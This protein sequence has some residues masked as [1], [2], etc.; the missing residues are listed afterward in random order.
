MIMDK[1]GQMPQTRNNISAFLKSKGKSVSWPQDKSMTKLELLGELTRL[2]KKLVKFENLDLIADSERSAKRQRDV[3]EAGRMVTVVRDSNDAITIQDLKGKITA[4]NRRAEKMYGYSKEEALEMNIGRLTPPDKEAEQKDFLRRIFA[5]EKITSFETQR[6]TKDGRL[7][8]VWL[9]VTKLADDAGKVIGIASTERDITERKRKEEA[10]RETNKYLDTLFS[11]ANVPIIVWDRQFKITRFNPAF[12]SLTGRISKDV[13]GGPLEVLFPPSSVE[14]SMELIKN[15]LGGE[16]WEIVEIPIL[17]LDGSVRTLLWNSATIFADEGKT[18]IAAIA[19]GH[20]I[21]ERKQVEEVLRQ[22]EDKYRM[23][24]EFTYDWVYWLDNDHSFI[25]SS[26]SCERI[27]GHTDEEFINDPTL[28]LR[29]IHPDDRAL[30][31]DHRKTYGSNPDHGDLDFRI[32]CKDGS[33]KW[34]GH[35]CQ[36]I[37]TED[38]RYLGRRSG[39]RDITER[40]R[41]EEGSKKSQRLLAETEK[42][43]KI[44]GWEFNI[45]TG[46]QAWTEEVCAIHEVDLTY[47][48]TVEKGVNFYAPAFRPIIAEAVKRAIEQGEPFDIELEIITAKGNLRS[49][50]AIGNADLENRRV[51]GFFQDI[52]ERKQVE[53]RLQHTR[54]DLARSN[55]ELEQFAYVASHDLQ[56]PLRMVASY[57]QLIEKRYKGKLLDADAE[58]FFGYAVDGAVRMKAMIND[59][60]I[61]SRQDT[62]RKD[63]ELVDC[64]V[65]LNTVL[66]GLVVAIKESK[67]EITSD[68]LSLVKGDKAQL[69]RLFHNLMENAIKFRSEVAPRIHISCKPQNGSYLFSIRDNGIG[70]EPQYFERIF[71]IFQRL[72]ERERF[73]G[74]GIGLAM[75]KKIVERHRGKIWIESEPGKGTTFYFTLPK[76]S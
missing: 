8:D 27:T 22:S 45:D 30:M 10:L 15:M 21:T 37:I 38:G 66:A 65:V 19:Q 35:V 56:E 54:E 9:T 69:A 64:T 50:H 41:A 76:A 7:I 55:M 70:I 6:L 36:P 2:R 1:T 63:P 13:V 75:C 43:G 23:L 62:Q 25:Y 42:I 57:L 61:I 32:I 67:A 14:S 34:I 72:H 58:E 59:L 24:S 20:D 68:P 49:V 74:T 46:K 3:E 52:T 60:L 12:E 48:P 44:G 11:C 71:I 51:H 33:E 17:H 28:F 5:G 18:P 4:W 29:I 53:K 26:P 31:V 73:P 40:K 47:D 39:N 16:R